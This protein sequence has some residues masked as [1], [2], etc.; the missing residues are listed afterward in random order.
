MTSIKKN[1]TGLN[2]KGKTMQIKN[3]NKIM[4]YSCSFQQCNGQ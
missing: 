2:Y 3:E 4:Y 1:K